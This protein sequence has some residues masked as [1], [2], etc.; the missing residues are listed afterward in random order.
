M[1]PARWWGFVGDHAHR[2]PL[3]PD[4]SSDHTDTELL[5]DLEHRALIGKGVDDLPHVVKTQPVLR[6]GVAQWPLVMR[7]P[8]GDRALEVGEVLLGDFDCL[9]LVL[10]RD[11]HYPVWDLEGHRPDLLW[12][13][14][15]KPTPFDHRRA[16]HRDGRCLGGDDDVTA[17]HQRR[18]AGEGPAVDDG[19]H[20]H[21][22]TELREGGEGVGVEGHSGPHVVVARTAAATLTEED[23]RESEP[24]G[25]LVHPVLLVVVSPALGAGQHRIVVVHHDGP[26]ALVV[27]EVAVDR[28]SAGDETVGGRL[29]AQRLHVVAL[30]LAR[31][32]QRPVLLERARVDEL[33]DVLSRHAEAAGTAL[34]DRLLAVLV[35]DVRAALVELLEV[36]TDVVGVDLLGSLELANVDLRLLDEHDRV[37]L[38][39]HVTHRHRHH[40]DDA[41]AVGGDRVLHLHRFENRDLLAPAD[42]V[43]RGDV[44]RNQGALNRATSPTEPSGPSCNPS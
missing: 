39:N 31:D 35:V 8:I 43:V 26:R 32:D 36:A 23:E 29:P 4:E 1:A 3:D 11:V 17:G 15:A 5:A 24:F 40:P 33:G 19:D 37:A 44:E 16:A 9:L 27:E 6:H 10:H 2:P 18:V 21:Q 28:A 38:A 12:R 42:L 25:E 34:R 14:D 30:V 7:L 41:V 20:R 13:V 22:P